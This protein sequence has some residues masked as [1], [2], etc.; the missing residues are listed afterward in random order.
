MTLLMRS[1][2]PTSKSTRLPGLHVIG[3]GVG[4]E[5]GLGQTERRLGGKRERR[6]AVQG[7]LGHDV[8]QV[9]AVVDALLR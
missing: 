9:S 4:G 8:D 5:E 6:V 7:Q 3:E 2:M 1:A